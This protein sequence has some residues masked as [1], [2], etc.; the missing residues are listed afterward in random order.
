MHIRLLLY[1]CLGI[2]NS[3]AHIL[4]VF[5]VILE[6]LNV[7]YNIFCVIR[8]DDRASSIIVPKYRASLWLLPLDWPKTNIHNRSS[9]LNN[10]CLVWL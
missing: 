9:N 2:F 6:V 5:L 8:R 4:D 3:A 10:P 1:I 7:M